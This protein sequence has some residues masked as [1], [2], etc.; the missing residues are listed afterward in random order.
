[1]NAGKPF[2]DDS[3][4]I[5]EVIEVQSCWGSGTKEDPCR[6]VYLYFSKIGT[7]LAI[8]DSQ[9]PHERMMFERQRGM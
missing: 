6:T 7:L 2:R 4:K 3:A 9:Q 1:M 8:N 5:M